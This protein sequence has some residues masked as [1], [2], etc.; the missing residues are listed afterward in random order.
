MCSCVADNPLSPHVD[1]SDLATPPA[2]PMAMSED[3]NHSCV[4]AKHPHILA[5]DLPQPPADTAVEKMDYSTT[6]TDSSASKQ[7]EESNAE[8]IDAKLPGSANLVGDSVSK[9]DLHSSVDPSKV[10]ST[11]GSNSS[12]V[13]E[14][15]NLT[16]GPRKMRTNSLRIR[17]SSDNSN[18]A[19]EE[20]VVRRAR[21]LS[22]YRAR[23]FPLCDSH[24]A[25]MV[26]ENSEVIPYPPLSTT[27]HPLL[28]S[29]DY[30]DLCE[31]STD[32]DTAD[33]EN[34]GLDIDLPAIGKKRKLH[35]EFYVNTDSRKRPRKYPLSI[36]VPDA[37]DDSGVCVA[38]GIKNVNSKTA[39]KMDN[40]AFTR[41]GRH[42]LGSCGKSSPR[43]LKKTTVR[44]SRFHLP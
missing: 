36:V 35:H 13:P 19:N 12:L 37:S 4:S 40:N 30:D 26:Q 25:S 16:P 6:E 7:V 41:F 24:Y 34:G 8:N 17:S 23:Q 29:F 10:N 5:D 31:P 3:S 32:E 33:R 42:S 11:S 38:P 2:T 15:G 28:H 27:N 39:R 1:V 43:T 21:E 18:I 14:A 22:P 20:D 9:K 44:Y